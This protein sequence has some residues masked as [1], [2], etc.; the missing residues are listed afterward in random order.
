MQ[1]QN[2]IST[3]ANYFILDSA[4]MLHYVDLVKKF[5]YFEFEQFNLLLQIEIVK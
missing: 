2:I 4:E 3:K 5:L 1:E